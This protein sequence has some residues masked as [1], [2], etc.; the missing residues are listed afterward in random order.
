MEAKLGEGRPCEV[1]SQKGGDVGFEKKEKKF[2]GKV[3]EK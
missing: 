2:K 1:G 3:G